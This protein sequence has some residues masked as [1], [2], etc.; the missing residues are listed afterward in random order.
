[1]ILYASSVFLRALTVLME[2]ASRDGVVASRP[3]FS[4][5]SVLLRAAS[6]V[7]WAAMLSQ[8]LARNCFVKESLSS[9][10]LLEDGSDGIGR[11]S[12][13]AAWTLLRQKLTYEASRTRLTDPHARTRRCRPNHS[14][15]RLRQGLRRRAPR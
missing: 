1:M 13:R 7:Q 4:P 8:D 10:R 15:R 6:T 2:A 12:R 14:C 5:A 9:P 11:P 3:A